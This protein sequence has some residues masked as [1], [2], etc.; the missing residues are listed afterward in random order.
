[1]SWSISVNAPT[2]HDASGQ[3]QVRLRQTSRTARPPAAGHVDQRHLPP[4]S[5]DGDDSAPAAPHRRGRCLHHHPQPTASGL[6]DGNDVDAGQA[7]E[8]VATVAVTDRDT[9]RIWAKRAS[10]RAVF[11]DTSRPSGAE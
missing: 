11:S 6:L 8:Q 9:S 1:M 5:S 4:T 10:S 7:D 3:R 2:G